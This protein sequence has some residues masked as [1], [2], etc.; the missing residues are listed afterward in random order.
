MPPCWTGTTRPALRV[1]S[2][3]RDMRTDAINDQRP[4][5]TAGDALRSPNRPGLPSVAAGF[6]T[7]VSLLLG[8]HGAASG[9]DRRLGTLGGADTAQNHLRLILTGQH[10][11]RR[12]RVGGGTTAA[13]FSVSRS[14]PSSTGSLSSSDRSHLDVAGTRQRHETTLRQAT[15]QRHLTALETDLVEAAGAG[16]LTLWPRPRVC[17]GRCRCH[18]RLG[19]RPSSTLGGLG[20]YSGAFQPSHL[21][22]WDTLL[23]IPRTRGIRQFD[24]CG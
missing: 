21:T 24:R 17:P 23:I 8:R 20:C 18:D 7:T 3:N 22:R 13:C 5:G 12:Q 9:F 14:I 2:R 11:L 6:A 15:L 10:D 1:D 19:A 16:F 4:P